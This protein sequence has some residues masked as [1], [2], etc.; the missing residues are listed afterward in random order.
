MDL[1]SAPR[2]LALAAVVAA[3]SG[4]SACGPAKTTTA[5]PSKSAPTVADSSPPA[6]PSA[7]ASDQPSTRA[8]SDP[9]SAS[10]TCKTSAMTETV[11][12]G[13][14]G[15]GSV[16]SGIALTNKS[17]TACTV[18][19]FPTLTFVD[20][21][22]KAYK[23]VVAHAKVTAAKFTVAAGGKAYFTVKLGDVPSSGQKA[24][25]CDPPAAGMLIS[26]S[27]DGAGALTDKG[28][29]RACGSAEVGPLTAKPEP[30]LHK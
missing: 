6:E 25:P 24:G 2:L 10:G 26:L 14:A 4:A 7:G 16:Y 5:S 1:R 12:G 22:G 9:S 21:N 28:P 13:D 18:S 8:S 30:G 15:A 23:V 20:A 3:V 19:G 11:Y 17:S 27:T 29:W